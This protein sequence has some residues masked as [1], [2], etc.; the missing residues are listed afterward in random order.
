MAEPNRF[1]V[2]FVDSGGPKE[3]QVQSWAEG[4]TS[5]I[6]FVRWRQFDL[7]G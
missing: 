5:L 4:S 7:N 1:A 6:V 3:A 2:W